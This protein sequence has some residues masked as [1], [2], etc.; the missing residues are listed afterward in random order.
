MT[1]PVMWKTGFIRMESI[2]VKE[3]FVMTDELGL[4]MRPAKNICSI[5]VE[6]PCGI[7][8]VSGSRTFNAKSVLGVLSACIRYNDEFEIVC[9]GEKEEEA[10]NALKAL[11]DNNFNELSVK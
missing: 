7:S 8:L 11:A 1:A 10:M 3:K 4:H 9:D 6:Y 5:A 2:M